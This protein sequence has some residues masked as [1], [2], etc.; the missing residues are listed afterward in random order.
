MPA[1]N[2]QGDTSMPSNETVRHDSRSRVR[3]AVDALVRE[4]T[5]RLGPGERASLRR[6]RPGCPT[7]PTFWIL[8]SRVVE[9]HD[10]PPHDPEGLADW[11]QRWAS[12]ARCVAELADLHSPTRPLGTALSEAQVSPE[13]VVRLLGARAPTLFDEIRRTGHLV[14]SRATRLDL[15]D[16]AEMLRYDDGDRA[17]AVRRKVARTYYAAENRKDST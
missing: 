11:E 10:A 14:L 13:R 9:A 6:L 4:V 1:E 3:S 7:T 15:G 12:I 8:L 2:I 16:A 5:T 17:D